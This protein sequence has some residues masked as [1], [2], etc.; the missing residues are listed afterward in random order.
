MRVVLDTNVLIS[1]T[2]WDG[3]V[4][5][6]LLYKL[7]KSNVKIFSSVEILAEYQKV[8]H[9]D[10]EYS[11]EDIIYILERVVSF[12]NLVKTEEKIDVVKNDPSDNKII[13]CAVTSKSNLIVTY[14]KHL[15]GIGKFRD[16]E[17]IKPE[18]LINRLSDPNSTKS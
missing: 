6:K 16:I 11:E 5:Q 1:A 15:L 8:L 3:S 4:A 12:V 2:L 14:D 7:I 18:E 13:E 10:F 17:I 9:R